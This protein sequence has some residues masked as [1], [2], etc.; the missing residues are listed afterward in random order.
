M[1]K[2]YIL[3]LN[4][5]KVDPSATLFNGTKILAHV[6]E[7]R[8]TRVKKG[9]NQFP[10]NA[11]KYCLS[12]CPNG[13]SDIVSINLGF[14]LNMFEY[15]V[16]SYF[17]QEWMEYPD[18]PYQ[19]GIYELSRLKEK[20]PKNLIKKI[21]DELLKIG[22]SQDQLPMIRWYNHHYC[23]A[24][25]AHLSS[26]FKNSLSVVA[27]GN[28]EIDTLSVF[29]CNG[30][31]LKKIYSMALPH[32]L[33]WL[34]RTF[35]LFCGFDAYEG[36][37]ML[38]GLAPYGKYDEDLEK[39]VSK[40]LIW[41][42]DSNGEFTFKI[43]AKYLYLDKRDE[44][45]P[46]ITKSFIKLFGKPSKFVQ[47]PSTYYKDLA[48]AIQD[49]FEKT[50]LG[51]VKRFLSKTKHRYLT[52]S[53]GVFLNCKVNGYIWKNLDKLD[54]IYIFPLSSDDGIGVG[55]NMS[56]CID[57]ISKKYEDYEFTNVYL[58]NSF[59][60]EEIKSFISA[61]EINK[62]LK[63]DVQYKALSNTLGFDINKE[64]LNDN[65]KDVLDNVKIFIK[66]NLV[67][68]NNIT[69]TVADFLANGKVIAFF[70]G[71]ME[72][73]PRALGNRSILADPRD[74][75]SLNKVNLK[76]KFRQPWRPFCPSVLSEF[77]DEYFLK[78]IQ[79][80]YMINTFS[81]T[82][83]CQEEAPAIVHL[84][85]TA[86]PQF[87]N[88]DDNPLYYGLIKEFYKIT[89]V[90]ILMNT[91]MNIKGEPISCTPYDALNFFFA[92]DIDILVIGNYII[93]KDQWGG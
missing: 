77:A 74:I 59:S 93:S 89:N 43:D 28:S 92:T 15:E 75:N 76:V 44:S 57:N 31:S 48:Y 47:M 29:D 13:I 49:R 80:P 36:E 8:Y 34:Y 63:K 45:N 39:K 27:D 21:Q 85:K 11:I 60:N 30:I 18:K 5:G 50:I 71:R 20:N 82:K 38:M 16:P 51:L 55:A 25:T 64:Y 68:C 72:A 35:T 84:D 83:K 1:S 46:Y 26:G 70:Q 32:S 86:R 65:Y 73:G 19:A 66:K 87:L 58:G 41:E 33:G 17:I 4:V 54:D 14:D 79:S 3:G 12:L 90:P 91:S 7:E 40:V 2:I 22:I 81:C 24:L 42:E 10:I 52:L 6:E 78:P 62:F 61:F 53:G 9:I 88:K 69:K 23:H 67:F 56:Y 37:G